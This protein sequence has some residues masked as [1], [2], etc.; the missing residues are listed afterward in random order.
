MMAVRGRHCA[1]SDQAARSGL[2]AF[3][4]YDMAITQFGFMGYLVIK[5]DQL[6]IKGS[7]EDMEGLVHFW[8]TIGYMI[9]IDDR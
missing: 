1:A 5:K 6:G 7:R 3:S 4:Q 2:G 9:G 8:R